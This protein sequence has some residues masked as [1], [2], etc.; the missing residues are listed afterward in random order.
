MLNTYA[1][2]HSSLCGQ[3]MKS[4][5]DMTMAQ[6]RLQGVKAFV[7]IPDDAKLLLANCKM[8]ELYVALK[9]SEVSGIHGMGVG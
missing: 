4:G 7:D 9:K 1:H 8:L 5:I 6:S 2:R 3:Q